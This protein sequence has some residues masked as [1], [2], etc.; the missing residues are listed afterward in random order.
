MKLEDAIGFSVGAL[1][2]FGLRTILLLLA[3]SI[4]VC[5]V[6]L[7]TSLG[8][9]ARRFIVAEFTTLGTNLLVVLPGKS[10]TAGAQPQLTT[11]A[12]PKELT[13]A[14]ASALYRS[15]AIAQVAPL[16]LGTAPASAGA[17]ARDIQVLGSTSEL[18]AVRQLELVHGSFLSDID[19]ARASSDCVLGAKVKRE[20]FGNRNPLG[21]WLRLND[22]RF[23]VVGVLADKGQS[24][25]IDF[26]DVVIIPVASAQ[27]LFNTASLLR[28]LVAAKSRQSVGSAERDILDIIRKRHHGDEDVTVVA[29]DAVLATFDRIFL[30]LTLTVGGIA[31]ISLAVAGIL[32]MNVMLVSVYQRTPEIGLLKAVGARSG[33]ILSLFLVESLL[34]SFAGAVFG[35]AAALSLGWLVTQL[36]PDFPLE[37]PLWSFLSAI[38]VSMAT[39]LLFGIAPARRA[40][41]LDPV[42]ALSRRG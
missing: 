10:E 33:H 31:A 6:V 38:T 13:L 5:S 35:V 18:L 26:N 2:G 28:I 19:P 40:A 1:R 29:Q 39:G 9:A 7:L 14:D 27:A 34:L 25:G 42:V 24:I 17:R 20:L 4:G 15:T 16:I 22:R 36:L 23:R 12:I 3:M 30:A 11:G 37:M 41:R 32:I 21:A 8:D